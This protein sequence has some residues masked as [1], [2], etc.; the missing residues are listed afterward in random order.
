MSEKTDP[1]TVN[2]RLKN[3]IKGYGKQATHTIVDHIF[4]GHLISTGSEEREP[5]EEYMK[6]M[7][8]TGLLMQYIPYH[9]YISN[10]SVL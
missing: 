5:D 10:F 6:S 3:M 1:N 2:P 8:K 7:N 4:G 9:H